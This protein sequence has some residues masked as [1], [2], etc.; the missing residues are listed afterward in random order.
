MPGKILG[1]DY[2]TRRIGLALSDDRGVFAFPKTILA[3]NSSA[4]R[5]IQAMIEAEGIGAIVVGESLDRKG[6]PNTVAREIEAFIRELQ[7]FDLPIYKE[8]EFFTSV[9]ARRIQGTREQ[10]DASAAALILQRYLD[11]MNHKR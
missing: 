8:K 5:T 11:K 10:V 2:G 6:R 4:L 1:I 7:K 3:S 9:E